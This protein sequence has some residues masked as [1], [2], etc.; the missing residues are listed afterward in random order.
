M[1]KLNRDIIYLILKELQNDNK[2]LYSCLM[3]NRTWCVTALPFLWKNPL[4]FCRTDNSK[5]IWAF[6]NRKGEN[7]RE[8]P[9]LY[10]YA[11]YDSWAEICPEIVLTQKKIFPAVSPLFIAKGPYIGITNNTLVEVDGTKPSCDKTLNSVCS[12]FV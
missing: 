3:V 5:N 11:K 12:R 10:L 8:K 4:K 6:C 2:S 7:C 9:I 1:S